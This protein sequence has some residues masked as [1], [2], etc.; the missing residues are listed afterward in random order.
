MYSHKICF[1][2]IHIAWLLLTWQDCDL[3][4]RLSN[5]SVFSTSVSSLPCPKD[6]WPRGMKPCTY[7]SQTSVYLSPFINVSLLLNRFLFIHLSRQRHVKSRGV[8]VVWNSENRL[9]QA[10]VPEQVIS[11]TRL[12]MPSVFGFPKE[13]EVKLWKSRIKLMHKGRIQKHKMRPER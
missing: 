11:K 5:S 1:D 4:Y 12:P 10:D 9:L 8:S 13:V 6:H 3:K 7:R 2:T